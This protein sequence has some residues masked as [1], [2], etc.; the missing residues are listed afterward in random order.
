[1]TLK[2][3]ADTDGALLAYRLHDL[4]TDV[5]GQPARQR[6]QGAT[7]FLWAAALTLAIAAPWLLPGYIFGTDWSGPRRIDFPTSL[8]AMAPFLAVLAV[9]AKV[10][11]GEMA[12][13]LLL[14]GCLF[15]A[16][17]TAYRAL[18]WGGFVPRAVGSLIYVVNPFVYGRLHYGQVFLLAGYAILPWVATRVRLLLIDPEVRTALLLA[19]GLVVLGAVDLHLLLEAVVLL[20]A[21]VAGYLALQRRESGYLRRLAFA[22][23]GTG[24]VTLLASA[25]WLIPLAIGKSPEGAALAHIGSA[26]IGVYSSVADPRL[27]LL[28]NL[29]GLYGFWAEASGRF[30]SLKLFAPFWPVVLVAIVALAVVGAIV[31]LRSRP[32]TDFQ[33]Q[34]PWVAGLLL[35]AAFALFLDVGVSDPHVAPV[36]R[37]L[38]QVFPPYRGMRDAAKWAALLALV[39]AQLVPVS[40]TAL[41]NRV[42]RLRSETVRE[43]S[44]ALVMGLALALPL[45]YGNGLLFGMHGQVRPSP[46]PSGWYEADRILVADP[47]PGRVLFLPWHLYLS[48]SFVRNVDSIVANPAPNFFSVPVVISQNPEIVGL[49]PPDDPDQ[50]ALAYL[51]AQGAT[52][53]WAKPLAAHN[54]KYVILAREVDW[55]AYRYF[56][57]QP[58]M[59]KVADYGSLVLYRNLLWP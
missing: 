25:Y 31:V 24:G 22:L 6:V 48:F 52:V 33:E 46:Y 28:P 49:P 7:P 16:A 40:V 56:E 15:G 4:T 36:V 26:D 5:P 59:V 1:M 50:M 51:V 45:Y 23:L 35:V 14:L 13:K 29:L 8:T 10:L 17:I 20:A 18:P 53:D 19:A 12:T 32:R 27:G 2:E 41:L 57:Y 11:S 55:R 3:S 21:I 54:I 37:W 58:N 39:Y 44:V 34:R 38:D 42:N 43:I 47:H 9:V 30:P